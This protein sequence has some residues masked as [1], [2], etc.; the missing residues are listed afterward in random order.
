MANSF[1]TASP[2]GNV[3]WWQFDTGSGSLIP[4]PRF[5]AGPGADYG[6][7]SGVQCLNPEP[8]PGTCLF[9]ADE[10]ASD[11]NGS[12]N[13]IALREYD[14]T[15]T[16]MSEQFLTDGAPLPG[17]RSDSSRMVSDAGG[18]L[19]VSWRD[20]SAGQPEYVVRRSPDS[21]Q[22][23][24]PVYR[25]SGGEPQG[26]GFESIFDFV[27]KGYSAAAGGEAYFA[28]A[29]QRESVFFSGL[30]NVYDT[31]DFDRDQSSA[32]VDCNDSDPTAQATPTLLGNLSIGEISGGV[33]LSW[34]SQAA[35]AGSGTVYDL[36]KGSVGD[37]R[38]TGTYAA[39]AC[40]TGGETGASFDDLSPDPPS[41]TADYYLGRARNSC[42][43]A[44]Y[45]DASVN[46][47]P[48]DDLDSAGPCP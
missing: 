20:S 44:G 41:G 33:R 14:P 17:A 6:S 45:G 32:A 35:T 28:W 5:V 22:T 25:L 29:G 39:V 42:G 16:L 9:L 26:T 12:P 13:R 21:G 24:D 40:L 10:S 36:V 27:K 38:G 30:F 31:N 34:D 18:N 2:F 37:L 11:P 1:S 8:G 23:F 46:P 4:R 19:W 7:G 15:G 48:R 47:D 43:S 3:R